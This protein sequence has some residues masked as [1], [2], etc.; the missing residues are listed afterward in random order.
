MNIIFIVNSKKTVKLRLGLAAIVVVAVLVGLTGWAIYEAGYQQASEETEYIVHSVRAR[1]GPDWQASLR[2]ELDE[3]RRLRLQAES[4]LNA[5][6]GRLSLM[7]GHV[8]RLNALGARLVAMSDVR[9]IDFDLENPPG[10][11]GPEPSGDAGSQSIPDTLRTLERLEASLLDQQDKLLFMETMLI[12]EELRKRTTPTV[13]PAEKVWLSSVY[14]YR[15][16]PVTG[17]REF[18]KGV[19][20]AGKEGTPIHAVADGVVTMSGSRYGYGNM[21]EINHGDGLM[22]RYG[23]NLKNLVI[24]GDVIERGQVIAY[25]GTSGRSTGPHVHFEVLKDG[26]HINPKKYYPD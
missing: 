25:M 21:V 1:T 8:M 16:D 2:R 14:G 17:R 12:D 23:H 9:E 20:Y 5:M 18:H 26:K 3:S 15:A 19:D 10:L 24:V 11:G 22:T 6:A 7:Q 13:L 4:S